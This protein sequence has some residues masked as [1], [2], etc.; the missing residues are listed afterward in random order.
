[1]RESGFHHESLFCSKHFHILFNKRSWYNQYM[2]VNVKQDLIRLR[3]A[4]R[5]GKLERQVLSAIEATSFFIP[6]D[7]ADGSL[8]I[9]GE[10]RYQQKYELKARYI[11]LVKKGLIRAVLRN[12]RKGYKLTDKGEDLAERYSL[13]S[14]KLQRPWRWDRKWRI[15]IFDI[16]EKRRDARDELRSTLKTI[17]FIQLQKSAWVYPYDCFEA[18]D[19]IRRKYEL[20]QMV[21]YFTVIDLESDQEFRESFELT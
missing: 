20:G 5:V 10:R 3:K 12:G 13:G 9:T 6:F 1:M 8:S 4:Q 17:G 7:V 21:R 15:V 18:V 2:T 14:L 11:K 19:L 16:P